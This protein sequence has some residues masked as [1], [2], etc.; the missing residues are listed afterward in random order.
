MAKIYACLIGN[1]VCLDDDPNCKIGSKHASP[2]IWWEENAEI[3]AP[4]QTEEEHSLY[5]LPY[6]EIIY[7]NHSYRISPYLI[8]RVDF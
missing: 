8:Q 2:S 1:W 7:L 5:Y 6:V 4:H 3:W